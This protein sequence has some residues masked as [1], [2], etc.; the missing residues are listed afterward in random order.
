M[1]LSG[2]GVFAAEAAAGIERDVQRLTLTATLL[3]AGFLYWRFRS[4][5]VLALVAVPLL[6]A[7]LAGY[8][9]AVALYG[10]VHAIALGFGVT[11]LGVVVDYPILLLTL[12]RP[13]DPSPRRRRG[14]GRPC[15]WRRSRPRWACW[16]WSAPACPGW[17]RPGSSPGSGC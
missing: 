9:A 6:A 17:C 8:A 5:P 14:S 10:S 13:D 15:G 2:P 11:M 12:R 7:T 4:W 16:P 1:L 3:L